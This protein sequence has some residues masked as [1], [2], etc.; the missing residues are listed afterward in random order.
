[1]GQEIDKQMTSDKLERRD[2]FKKAGMTAIAVGAGLAGS[3]QSANAAVL[4]KKSSKKF[5][6]IDWRNR[7]PLKQ[8]SG[9]Y[10]SRVKLFVDRPNYLGNPATHGRVPDVIYKAGKEGAVKEWW[11]DVQTAGID[12]VVSNGRHVE[13]MPEVSI[14]NEQLITF[15]NEYKG[16]YYAQAGMNLDL[17]MKD[18]LADL[19]KAINGGLKGANIEPGYRQKNGGPTTIDDESLFPIYDY[20]SEVGLPLIAQTGVIAGLANWNEPNEIW[21]HDAVMRKFPKLKLVLS[22]AGYPR[23]TEAL[24]LAFLHPGVTLCTDI[25][26]FLPGGEIYQKNIDMLQDQFVF[27]TAFPY[28]NMKEGVDQTL[29]LPMSDQAMQKYLYDNSARLMKI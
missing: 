2:F 11:E 24:A 17:P 1:M 3:T 25:Y 20:M 5:K 28:G 27:A 19:E 9:L 29:A 14:S 18:I 26:T 4:S 21:R 13:G 10:D 7:P 22:H 16:K 12:I 15:Q 23:Q 8:F 6:I